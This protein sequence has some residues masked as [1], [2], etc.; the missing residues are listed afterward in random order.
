MKEYLVILKVKTDINAK[1][2]ESNIEYNLT[3]EK[4]SFSEAEVVKVEETI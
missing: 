4:S 3:R 2:V 1:D